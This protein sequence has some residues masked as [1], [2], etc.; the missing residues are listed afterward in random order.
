MVVMTI[1]V[2]ATKL[3]SRT[4]AEWS[5]GSVNPSGMQGAERRSDS[6]SIDITCSL[7]G[8][9]HRVPEESVVAAISERGEF[10]ALCGATLVPQPMVCPQ[11]P[12]CLRCAVPPPLPTGR[13]R[14]RRGTM[15]GG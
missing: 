13:P 8:L 7:D 5:S 1:P 10:R 3:M 11:G 14:H 6:P 15:S 4:G 12:P 2:W 9:R